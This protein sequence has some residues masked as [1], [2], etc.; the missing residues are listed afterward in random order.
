MPQHATK[1]RLLLGCRGEGFGVSRQLSGVGVGRRGSGFG[2]RV[3][4]V[5]FQV[6]GF[7]FQFSGFGCTE[8]IHGVLGRLAPRHA[9]EHALAHMIDRPEEG[10]VL[11]VKPRQDACAARVGEEDG[12]IPGTRQSHIT[13]LTK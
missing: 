7:G 4:G 6:S 2:F 11:E 3:S 10:L 9:D 1:R 8:V 5:G 13:H 12:S